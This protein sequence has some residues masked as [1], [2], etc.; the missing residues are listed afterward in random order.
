MVLNMIST[1]SMIKLGR[2][3]EGLMIDMQPKSRKLRR[4]AALIISEIARVDKATAERALR[5]ARGNIRLAILSLGSDISTKPK[6]ESKK[7]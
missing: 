6:P 4:R 1:A 2:V 3:Y 7:K 5:K